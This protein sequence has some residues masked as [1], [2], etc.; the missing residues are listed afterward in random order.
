MKWLHWQA[1]QLFL[2]AR[3]SYLRAALQDLTPGAGLQQARE[4]LIDVS[5]RVQVRFSPALC[6]ACLLKASGVQ[7]AQCRQTVSQ[8]LVPGMSCSCPPSMA[9]AGAGP[10]A[11]ALCALSLFRAPTLSPLPLSTSPS[12]PHPHSLSHSQ[13]QAGRGRVML[14][15]SAQLRTYARATLAC[16]RPSGR[17]GSCSWAPRETST[18]GWWWHA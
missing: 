8:A 5:W 7:S 12:L 16:R 4:L 2:D 6:P 1:L 3:H 14:G 13:Q 18:R 17:L 9:H 10:S 11:D 15:T